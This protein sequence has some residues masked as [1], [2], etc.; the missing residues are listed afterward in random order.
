MI[1]ANCGN[2]V[3]GNVRACPRCGYQTTE[4]VPQAVNYYSAPVGL[5]M[6]GMAIASLVLGIIS[7][8]SCVCYGIPS[9]VCGILAVVF[10]RK[11]D[12]AVANGLA[13]PNSKGLAMA[14]RICG[15]VGLSFG[16]VYI[17]FLIVVIV[18]TVIQ[19]P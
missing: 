7:I 8:P 1:C 6:S 18:M 15:W 2:N 16:L 3:E 14:G 17:L 10:A 4:Q 13:A 9:I 5:S 19:R 11:A 12:E